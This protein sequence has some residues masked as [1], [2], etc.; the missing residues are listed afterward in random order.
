M[1]TLPV[2]TD[3][4]PDP[5]PLGLRFELLLSQMHHAP[6]RATRQERVTYNRPAPRTHYRRPVRSSPTDGRYRLRMPT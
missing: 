1:R 2:H 4:G 5:E 6:S 3:L